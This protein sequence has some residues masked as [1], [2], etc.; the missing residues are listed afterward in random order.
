MLT[1]SF[2]SD[3]TWL[4][5]DSDIG[6]IKQKRLSIVKNGH[7]AIQ[8]L[9]KGD[10]KFELSVSTK[11]KLI[12]INTF[13][14]KEVC[15]NENTS[16]SLMTTLNWDECKEFATRKAPFFVYDV[17]EP[18]DNISVHNEKT[19]AVF[20]EFAAASNVRTGLYKIEVL[21]KGNLTKLKTQIELNVVNAV[22]PAVGESKFGVF[23]FTSFEN[24]AL[25]HNAKNNS[26]RYWNFYKKHIALQLEMRASH[27][28]VP[29]GVPIYENNSLI[30][31]DFSACEKAG[32]IALSLDAPFIVISPISHWKNW[33]DS[34]YYTFWNQEKDTSDEDVYFELSKYFSAL[35]LIIKKN[36]WQGRVCLSLADEPQLA[37]SPNYRVLSAIARKYLPSVKIIEAIEATNLGGSLDIW[38]PKQETFEKNRIKFERLKNNGEDIWFY[39]CAFPAGS[40]MNRSMDLPLSVSRLVLWMAVSY[41]LSGYLHWGWNYYIGQDV[42]S[43]AC[44]PHKGALLPAGDA[45]IVYPMKNTVLRSVRYEVQKL[46]AEEVILMKKLEEK[47]CDVKILVAKVC[48]DYKHYSSDG[49][50]VFETRE[51]IL[52]L[53][54]R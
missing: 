52:S 3:S 47:G 20:I 32:N 9:I 18:I 41:G 39:T 31:F 5:P 33:D 34:E 4:Y 24:I 25:D 50:E 1:Y 6:S 36:C 49:E 11:S 37:N 7:A 43:N 28:M 53:F 46:A 13:K 45:H 17:L 54:K 8:L 38:V 42:F 23:D 15:V 14:E 44:C 16:A 22:L 21:I 48:K 2:F 19:V 29:T 40:A 12:S 51:E 35:A 27:I 10:E 26:S 30:D